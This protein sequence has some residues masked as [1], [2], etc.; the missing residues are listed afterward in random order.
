[1]LE[2]RGERQAGRAA[3]SW[4]RCTWQSRGLSSHPHFPGQTPSLWAVP[5]A[6]ERGELA[7]LEP[8]PA[9]WINLFHPPKK[10]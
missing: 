1:M 7:T 2:E 4:R 8:Q 9:D 3:P 6:V 5:Q 10:A